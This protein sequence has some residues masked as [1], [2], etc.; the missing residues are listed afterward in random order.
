VLGA[1]PWG[2]FGIDMNS[3]FFVFYLTKIVGIQFRDD[4]VD[5]ITMGTHDF[6][7]NLNLLMLARKTSISDCSEIAGFGNGYEKT[8]Y[9]S[10][11]S[12]DY[13]VDQHHVRGIFR[14]HQDLL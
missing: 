13:P 14:H 11:R 1:P 9:P 2:F 6:Q 7:L 4:R 12:A 8:T 5:F 3:S 10:R